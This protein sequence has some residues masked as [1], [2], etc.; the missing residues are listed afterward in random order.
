LG[1][2]GPRQIGCF[3]SLT[4]LRVPAGSERAVA[5]SGSALAPAGMS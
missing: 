2:H 1:G 3:Q 5:L 4:P